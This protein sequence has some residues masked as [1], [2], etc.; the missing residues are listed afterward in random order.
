[1][2]GRKPSESAQTDNERETWLANQTAAGKVAEVM[3][4]RE[5]AKSL[6]ADTVATVT[7]SLYFDDALALVDSFDAALA[8][9]NETH[10]LSQADQEPL[11]G[12]GFRLASEDDKRRL[13]GVP[14]LLMEWTFRESDFGSNQDW[15][16]IRAVQRGENGEAIKWIINDGSTGIAKDLQSFS[17]KTGRT[18][19][20]LVKHGL[21][22]SKYYIDGNKES[23]TF[24]TAL[25]KKQVREYMSDGRGKSLAEASTFY[26]DTSA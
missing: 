11:L 13:I 9:A 2:A 21:S 4:E 12:D 3:T 15:V 17:E 5:I 6:G 18:G 25:S 10:G 16:S 8:L 19:G 26:L 20:L 1:M 14:L 24:G 7:T 23:S 22:E